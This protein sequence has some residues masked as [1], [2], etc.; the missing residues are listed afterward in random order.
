LTLNVKLW[1]TATDQLIET[2]EGNGPVAFSPDDSLLAFCKYG[3]VK[4][5]DLASLTVRQLSGHEWGV[6]SIRFSPDGTQLFTGDRRAVKMWDVEKGTMRFDMQAHADEVLGIFLTPDSR[7][8]STVGTDRR[9]RQWKAAS[10][11]EVDEMRQRWQ[12]TQGRSVP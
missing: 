9:I 12:E 4:L 10:A 3:T 7:V 11:D 8:L 5:L 1:D 6:R 2:F